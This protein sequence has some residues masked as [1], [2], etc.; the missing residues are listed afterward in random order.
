[1]EGMRS[2]DSNLASNSL[3]ISLK[4]R[5]MPIFMPLGISNAIQM[6]KN[7]NA[8]MEGT[9]DL[10]DVNFRKF[11]LKSLENGNN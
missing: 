5:S 11:K 9:C 3:N 7:T 10:L 8:K 2:G 4:D 6:F 1:M